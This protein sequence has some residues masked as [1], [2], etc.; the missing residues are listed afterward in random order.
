MKQSSRD[1][2][3]PTGKRTRFSQHFFASPYFSSLLT[4]LRIVALPFAA[5]DI[6]SKTVDVAAATVGGFRNSLPAGA[7]QTDQGNNIAAVD[8]LLQVVAVASIPTLSEWSMFM[9][10]GFLAMA[11]LAA[12]RGRAKL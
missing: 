3:A 11:G 8:V 7:M 6:E 10:G 12:M 4:G 9:L 5:A 2:T 1:C